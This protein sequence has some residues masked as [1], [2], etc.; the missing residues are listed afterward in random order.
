[1][2]SHYTKS[3]M[4]DRKSKSREITILRCI[5]LWGNRHPSK[6][7][8]RIFLKFVDTFFSENTQLRFFT[9]NMIHRT[10]FSLTLHRADLLILTYKGCPP[11]VSLLLYVLP[12]LFWLAL[13]ARTSCQGGHRVRPPQEPWGR[14]AEHKHKLTHQSQ[15]RYQHKRADVSQQTHHLL[16][17]VKVAVSQDLLQ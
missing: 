10:W 6:S 17:T 16:R 15:S 12:L 5:K 3:Q 7:L 4:E 13:W 11:P 2:R 9:P 14:L 1:M 8:L